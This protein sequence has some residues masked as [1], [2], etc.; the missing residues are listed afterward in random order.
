N[1]PDEVDLGKLPAGH[2]EVNL[3]DLQ[4]EKRRIHRGVSPWG[5]SAALIVSKAQVRREP[6]ASTQGRCG[7]VEDVDQTGRVLA[8]GVTAHGGLVDTD[9]RATGIG[10]R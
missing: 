6:A 9:L 4:I 2:F 1:T 10:Q 7:P 8:M 5:D 3:V